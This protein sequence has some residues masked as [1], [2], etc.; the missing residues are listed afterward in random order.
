MEQVGDYAGNATIYKTSY[1]DETLYIAF[2]FSENAIDIKDLSTSEL[3]LVFSVNDAKVN[4][5]DLNL[6]ARGAAVLT[7]D[8]DITI[9]EVS[10][11]ALII[12]PQ[13]GE[14]YY[15]QL[16]M[17]DEFEGFI[18]YLGDNVYF[19]EGDIITLYNNYASEEWI[20]DNL[21]SWSVDGF[22][23]TSEGIKCIKRGTYDIYVKFK[24]EQDEIYKGNQ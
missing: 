12:Y 5:Y 18:Q 15:V 4:E 10:N 20:E 13:E 6:P 8:E 2:N 3:E 7:C 1:A 24:Y 9:T 16:T 21:S 22:N 19:N 14:K 17:V 23:S 11:Y